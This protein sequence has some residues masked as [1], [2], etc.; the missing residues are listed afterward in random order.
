MYH[1]VIFMHG[2]KMLPGFI[3]E[4]KQMYKEFIKKCLT[5]MI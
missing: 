3:E 2:K 1:S 5:F 4:L